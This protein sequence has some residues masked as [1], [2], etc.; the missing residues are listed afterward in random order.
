MIKSCWEAK[1]NL[2]LT[3]HQGFITRSSKL[4]QNSRRQSANDPSSLADY[5]LCDMM[6]LF[7][8]SALASYYSGAAGTFF[9]I[10]DKGKLL[11]YKLIHVH[12]T[13]KKYPSTGIP[14]TP[15]RVFGFKKL[16]LKP[17]NPYTSFVPTF[18]RFILKIPVRSEASLCERTGYGCNI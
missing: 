7:R 12:C 9:C 14:C 6:S 8:Y 16:F 10:N 15:V 17:Y 18:Q 3:S 1:T 5:I 11:Q 13:K 4:A 2:L